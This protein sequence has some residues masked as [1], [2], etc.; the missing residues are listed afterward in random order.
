MDLDGDGIRDLISGSWPGELFWFRGKGKGAFAPPV[1]LKDK[2]GKTINIGGGILWIF[3]NEGTDAAPRLAAGT[4][5]KGGS[6]DGT[7]PTG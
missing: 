4:K 7:V 5:F 1:K 3:S 6:K 2:D